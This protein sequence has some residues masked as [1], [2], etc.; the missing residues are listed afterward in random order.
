MVFSHHGY[1]INYFSTMVCYG[2]LW[3]EENTK[4][5]KK[6]EKDQHII[7][8][9]LWQFLT[10]LAQLP[11]AYSVDCCLRV[12]ADL[13]KKTKEMLLIPTSGNVW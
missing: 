13:K 7:T 10:D 9:V 11:Y 6:E 4:K 1:C 2:M 12:T 3:W 5:G 8:T